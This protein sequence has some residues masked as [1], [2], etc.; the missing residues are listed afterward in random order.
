MISYFLCYV[1]CF[2]NVD[3]QAT[4]Q[5]PEIPTIPIELPSAGPIDPALPTIQTAT[6]ELVPEIPTIEAPPVISITVQTVVDVEEIEKV[7]T[8]VPTPS[9]A[10]IGE[11]KNSGFRFSASTLFGL[12]LTGTILLLFCAWKFFYN[13]ASQED[14]DLHLSMSDDMNA[15]LNDDIKIEIDNNVEDLEENKKIDEEA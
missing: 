5:E 9:E 2:Q 4:P 13:S 6:P 11:I 12:A 15:A 14:L 3:V 8:K 10:N 7:P 1:V